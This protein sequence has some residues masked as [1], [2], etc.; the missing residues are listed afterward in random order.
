M[1][2]KKTQSN[3]LILIRTTASREQN[4]KQPEIKMLASKTQ[5]HT[6]FPAGTTTASREHNWKLKCGQKNRNPTDC[7]CLD[8]NCIELTKLEKCWTQIYEQ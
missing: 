3:R 4:W 7:V 8:H 5:S 6:L 1:R 2:E